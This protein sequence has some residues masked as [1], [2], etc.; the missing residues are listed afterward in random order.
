MRIC[1]LPILHINIIGHA[2]QR[3]PLYPVLAPGFQNERGEECDD[4]DDLS[5]LSARELSNIKSAE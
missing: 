2:L 3:S 5:V 1:C 4:G